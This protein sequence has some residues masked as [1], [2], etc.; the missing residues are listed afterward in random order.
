[1]ANN[2]E[3]F[4]VWL[5]SRYDGDAMKAAQADFKRTQEAA[6]KTD[7]SLE[8]MG[9]SA[10][11]LK[12]QLMSLLAFTEVIAQFREGFEQVQQLEQAMNQLERAAKRNGDNF[13]DVKS[14][15][16]AFADS[17]KKAAGVDDDAVIKGVTK[18]YTATGDLANSLSLARLAADVS[19]GTQKTFEES[20][21]L[22]T[23]AAQGNTRALVDL[24]LKTDE[25]T[26]ATLTAEEALKRISSAYGGAAANAKGLSVELGRMKEK[27]EDV[28]NEVVDRVTPS[29]SVAMK[30]VQS[31]FTLLDG[32]WRAV[33]DAF[34][35]T[36]GFFGKFGDYLKALISRDMSGMKAAIVAMGK[37]AKGATDSIVQGAKEAAKKLEDI[38]SGAQAKIVGGEGK[39]TGLGGPG[40]G[41][42][43]KGGGGDM[44]QGVF[45]PDDNLFKD[46]LKKLE[47]ARKA[48]QK[49]AKERGEAHLRYV[50]YEKQKRDFLEKLSKDKKKADEEELERAEELARKEKELAEQVK[51][52]KTAGAQASAYAA[53]GFAR[54]AFGESKALGVAEAGISTWQGAARALR[55][56]PAPYSYVVAALT[57]ANGLAQVAKITSTNPSTSGQGFDDPRNDA[58]A[59]LGGRRWAMDMIGEF[60]GGAAEIS[61]GWAQGMRG[62]GG[63][64]VTNDNRR[65]YNV[66]FNGGR[67]MNPNDLQ[68]AKQFKRTLDVVDRVYE[69]QRAVARRARS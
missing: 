58:A 57:I 40:G 22:V 36:V 20:L 52:A 30:L 54:S 28:R 65:T 29:I 62:A 34:V 11:A 50:G 12:T 67:L 51:E 25:D 27:W 39:P 48:E 68:M 16:L 61:R 56:Y 41:A 44:G 15:T 66:T 47:E 2:R 45:G 43:G 63:G 53:I 17:L 26:A 1:M 7:E 33:S 23:G 5:K 42:G 35:G 6:K 49:L 60:S 13:S 9:Y 31:F 4:E 59:R 10:N 24:G 37:E 8:H 3:D 14:K 32:A 18:L 69:G 46:Y 21:R 19:V 55:D 64:S 38:W